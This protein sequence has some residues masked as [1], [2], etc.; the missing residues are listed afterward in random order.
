MLVRAHR[1][2]KN[3]KRKQYLC[4]QSTDHIKR[5][6]LQSSAK[7][8]LRFIAIINDCIFSCTEF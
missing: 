4:L 8:L 5:I 3:D 7:K 1:L 6:I 2:G